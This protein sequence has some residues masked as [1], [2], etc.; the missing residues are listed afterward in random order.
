MLSNPKDQYEKR[1]VNTIRETCKSICPVPSNPAWRQ[2]IS[3]LS[4]T[5]LESLH[6]RSAQKDIHYKRR[7]FWHKV[8]GLWMAPNGVS[9]LIPLSFLCSNSK[10]IALRT[11]WGCSWHPL[12]SC[13]ARGHILNLQITHTFYILNK[14]VDLLYNSTACTFLTKSSASHNALIFH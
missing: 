12:Q 1:F 9:A 14:T 4:L 10:L 11:H 5:W 13:T 8:K 3:L 6:G 7:M 2:S